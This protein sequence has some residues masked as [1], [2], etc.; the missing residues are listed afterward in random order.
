MN[1]SAF[2]NGS[3]KPKKRKTQ[4]AP[5]RIV[6]EKRDKAV[7]NT[8][9][10][11]IWKADQTLNVS[12]ETTYIMNEFTNF[13]K[14]FSCEFQKMRDMGFDIDNVNMTL[15]QSICQKM[16]Y[17]NPNDK[18]GGQTIN[19]TKDLKEEWAD[20]LNVSTD[21]IKRYIRNMVAGGHLI[22]ISRGIY[23]VNPY[24]YGKGSDSDINLLR[25]RVTM[26]PGNGCNTPPSI[27]ISAE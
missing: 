12:S 9:T 21:M 18:Y 26:L 5:P 19:I 27:Y 15:L 13:T 23:M 4:I 1:N 20:M 25:T 16:S 3:S 10:G 7:I 6:T 8:D 2:N 22:R 17:A 14:T 24:L 11:E